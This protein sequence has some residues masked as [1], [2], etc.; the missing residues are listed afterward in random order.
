ME[1]CKYHPARKAKETCA[2]CSAK[3]CSECWTPVGD[4]FRAGICKKCL[5]SMEEA[6]QTGFDIQA[7]DIPFFRALLSGVGAGVLLLIAWV[8]TTGV[9]FRHIPDFNPFYPFLIVPAAIG[10]GFAVRFGAGMRRGPVLQKISLGVTVLV[11]LVGHYLIVNHLIG[12]AIAALPQTTASPEWMLPIGQVWPHL[13]IDP[14]LGWMTWPPYAI[15]IYAAF[16]VPKKARL[17]S[18]QT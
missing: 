18:R 15:A 10:I 8:G 6:A 3:L 13:L 1:R 11:L 16:T 9:A 7:R 17:R 2:K 4:E 14:P 12:L 5:A